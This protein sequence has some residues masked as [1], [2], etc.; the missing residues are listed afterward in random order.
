MMSKAPSVED[1]RL[2]SGFENLRKTLLADQYTDRLDKPLAFWALPSD[3]RLPLAFLG[4]TLRDLLQTPFDELLATRGVGK[5]KIS[6]LVKL[7][8]R[9]AA[10]KPVEPIVPLE[11]DAKSLGVPAPAGGQFDPAS[12]SEAMWSRWRET[13][14]RNRLEGEV[15]GRL[16]PSLQDL[17][18]VI[19]HVP[20]QFYLERDLTEI[21]QLKTHGE[22]RVRVVLEVFHILH[23]CLNR[24]VCDERL[25]VS[26]APRFIRPIE[27]W[28]RKYLAGD[29]PPTAKELRRELALPLLAQ[30]EIDTGTNVT[31]LAKQR[32]GLAGPAL[33]VRQQAKDLGVTR[34]RV[35]QLLDECNRVMN[36][37]WPEG[38][39]LLAMLGER[40]HAQS[41]EPAALQ[42]M[43]ALTSLF[44][45]SQSEL[46]R[47]LGEFGSDAT[48]PASSQS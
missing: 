7:L 44:F 16:A 3:R 30:L 46:T 38:G 47:S 20:L 29:E 39:W 19:W 32:I 6:S 25:D 40:M 2:T 24:Y 9:V 28:I 13:V 15:L 42:M 17:P 43:E 18:T 14:R 31:E 34:A 12:V 23:E 22:K 45:P 37:R 41:A 48:S 27:Q 10:S 33:N 1:F 35:Y 21:R 5:K 36:V 8:G 4:R 26:L 11:V